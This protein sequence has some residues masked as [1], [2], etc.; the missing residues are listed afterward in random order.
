M[1][2]DFYISL[3][4]LAQ[5]SETKLRYEMRGNKFSAEGGDLSFER[6]SQIYNQARDIGR[7][8]TADIES[9]LSRLPKGLKLQVYAEGGEY[10][11]NQKNN[12]IDRRLPGLPGEQIE[13]ASWNNEGCE[14]AELL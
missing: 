8:I 3:T 2:N 7:E 11:F 13:T 10:G 6:Q 12:G 1:K 5:E 14:H 4:F 9:I